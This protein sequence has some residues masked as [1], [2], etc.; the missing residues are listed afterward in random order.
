MVLL[1]HLE[2]PKEMAAMYNLEGEYVE[3]AVFSVQPEDDKTASN[4]VS[5][6]HFQ[7]PCL[8]SILYYV[9]YECQRSTHTH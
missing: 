9:H 6:N 1:S 3:L 7:T 5:S 2:A 4:E 8:F